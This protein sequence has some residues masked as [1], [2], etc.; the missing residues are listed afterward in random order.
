MLKL[1]LES[2]KV[3]NVMN[4]VISK[5]CDCGLNLKNNIKYEMSGLS[6]VLLWHADSEIVRV[7][8]NP[9]WVTD[10]R[11]GGTL[12]IDP[13]YRKYVTTNFGR[14]VLNVDIVIGL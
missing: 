1:N 4:P 2:N 9:G 5:L 7:V 10:S 13:H 12:V 3:N 6:S 8:G 11:G 14:S